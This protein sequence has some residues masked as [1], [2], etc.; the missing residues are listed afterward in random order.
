M[1]NISPNNPYLLIY[2]KIDRQGLCVDT[3]PRENKHEEREMKC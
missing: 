1:L 3:I 2:D